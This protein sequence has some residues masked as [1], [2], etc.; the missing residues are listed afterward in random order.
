MNSHSLSICQ[1]NFERISSQCELSSW[2]S[3]VSFH[4]VLHKDWIISDTE[5][6]SE[7]CFN[8]SWSWLFWAELANL[9]LLFSLYSYN[10]FWGGG[11]MCCACHVLYSS[12]ILISHIQ[13]HSRSFWAHFSV[14]FKVR[15]IRHHHSLLYFTWLLGHN[16]ETNLPRTQFIWQLS[17]SSM[18]LASFQLAISV[19][20][21]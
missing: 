10:F 15:I 4:E 16:R 2:K 11:R 9:K 6:S 19:F 20:S 18:Y 13:I 12:V 14:V 17:T 3:H 1:L 5:I 7:A 21:C 8:Y